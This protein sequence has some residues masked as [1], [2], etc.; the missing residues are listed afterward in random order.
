MS[1]DTRANVFSLFATRGALP[2]AVSRWN[3]ADSDF[4]VVTEVIPKGDYGVARAF[5]V[6]DNIPNDHFAYHRPWR[7]DMIMPNAGSY[8]WRLIDLPDA[9]LRQLILAFDATVAPQKAGKV[10]E[11]RGRV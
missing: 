7:E 10:G 9:Q 1:S 5:P 4:A 8:Q 11:G 3:W 6:R 2:F